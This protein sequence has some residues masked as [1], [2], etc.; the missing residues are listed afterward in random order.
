MAVAPLVSVRKRCGN[1]QGG[2]TGSL[3]LSDIAGATLG[4]MIYWALQHQA[5][6]GARWWWI[7]SPVIAIILLFIGLFLTSTGF[8]DIAAERRGHQ[9]Y[10]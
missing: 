9:Q 7:G 5:L 6:L 3:T 8:S 1:E 10:A 4:S 2:C